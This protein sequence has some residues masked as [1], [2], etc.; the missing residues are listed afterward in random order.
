[1]A[2]IVYWLS[3][4]VKVL[5]FL[6]FALLSCAMPALAQG[7]GVRVGF[8]MAT[9]VE[10]IGVYGDPAAHPNTLRKGGHGTAQ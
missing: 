10:L 5:L 4:R 6:V 9:E 8:V 7:V 2:P 1:M 3:R